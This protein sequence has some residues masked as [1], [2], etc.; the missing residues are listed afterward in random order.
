[1]RKRIRILGLV[2]ILG[3]PLLAFILS[4]I[5]NL[6]FN[7]REWFFPA[8]FASQLGI[9][10]AYGLSVGIIAL[11]I[12]NRPFMESVR[13]RYHVLLSN[14]N[15]SWFDVFFLSICAGVGEEILFR[16]A[17][18]GLLG[19]WIAAI[20][21]VAIH[22]YLNPKDWRISVYGVFMVLASAGFGYLTN[23]YGLLSAMVAHTMVD[24]YLLA[25]IKKEDKTSTFTASENDIS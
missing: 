18:Q 5:F 24:I 4:W 21:F 12:S 15:L 9:G 14:L 6:D 17:V 2:T 7:W 1:M 3:M 11:W 8:N 20:I 13:T 19:I 16:F 25:Q 10:L 23:F 22:G